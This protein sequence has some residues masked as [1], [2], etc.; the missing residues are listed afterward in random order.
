LFG[1][2]GSVP[3]ELA[4]LQDLALLHLSNNKN[5]TGSYKSPVRTKYN[6]MMLNRGSA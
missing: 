6:M 3:A 2:A 5:F 4:M 1:N